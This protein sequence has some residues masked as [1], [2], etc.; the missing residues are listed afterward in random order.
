MNWD[1]LKWELRGTSIYDGLETFIGSGGGNK[2]RKVA[3]R[4]IVAA[5]NAAVD[6]MAAEF[7]ELVAF[8]DE[9][10]DDVI[11]YFD[12]PEPPGARECQKAWIK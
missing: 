5:H 9:D 11:E 3:V 2:N 10:V 6:E 4:N 8:L 7:D 1:H 12:D